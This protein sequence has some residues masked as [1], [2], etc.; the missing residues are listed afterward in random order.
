M[1]ELS[2]LEMKIQHCIDQC[3][4]V[5]L[6][7]DQLAQDPSSRSYQLAIRERKTYLKVLGMI[8]QINTSDLD[9]DEGLDTLSTIQ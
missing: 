5:I 3:D 4:A 9:D 7:G 8:A 6:D 2:Y 1:D